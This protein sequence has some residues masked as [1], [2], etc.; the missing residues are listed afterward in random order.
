MCR[1]RS[2]IILGITLAG[3]LLAGCGAGGGT[4]NKYANCSGQYHVVQSGKLIVATD[5][6]YPPQEFVDPNTQKIVGFDVD[7]ANELAKRLNLTS[8][9]Q[10]IKFDTIETALFGPPVCQ[11]RYDISI[12]AWTIND[13]RK[14]EGDMIPYFQA[15]ESI[16]V[17]KG[18]PKHI[19]SKN[20]LCGLYV[21]VE[22]G[23]VEESEIDNYDG[24]TPDALNTS[25]GACA[26]NNVH[27]L[28]YDDQDQ[29]IQQL[30][31][32][33][34]DA[35]YQDSPVTDYFFGLNPNQLERGPVTVAPAPE[36]IFL[37][38]DNSALETAINNALNAMRSDGTYKQI[39]TQ[40]HLTDDAYPPI[41]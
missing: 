17:H 11:Q 28:K 15:G 41:S 38:N 13:K 3:T 16:L 23:T 7:I 36:G 29:A 37:R 33:R 19:Q 39:L 8:N 25:S 12:S 6:S 40:W 9:V 35:G 31:N 20:D 30:L 27:L 34:A 2:V 1:F 21:A 14:K 18:N 4:A 26:K 5:A 10:N 22:S 24:Q 32:G